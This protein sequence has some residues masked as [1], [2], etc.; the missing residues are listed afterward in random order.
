MQKRLGRHD[1]PIN[2]VAVS[3]TLPGAIDHHYEKV[4]FAPENSSRLS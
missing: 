2:R 4:I 3:L 1:S